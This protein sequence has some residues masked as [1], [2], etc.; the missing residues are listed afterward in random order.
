MSRFCKK[1]TQQ[2]LTSSHLNNNQTAISFTLP[3][4]AKEL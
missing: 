1:P 2:Q 4:A 3:K